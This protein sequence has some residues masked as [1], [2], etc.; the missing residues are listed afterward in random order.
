MTDIS[1]IKPTN[2]NAPAWTIRPA[3][4]DDLR[5]IFGTW[6]NSMWQRYH[7]TKSGLSKSNFFAEYPRTIDYILDDEN[8]RV[9]VAS[10]PEEP[11]VI[12]GYIVYNYTCIFAVFVKGA[13]RKWG[14]GTS[15]YNYAKGQRKNGKGN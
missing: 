4:G 13:F 12:Y 1:E 11:S 9:S 5:F 6:L 8:T 2:A 3:Q 10:D 15:L 7:N 14:I